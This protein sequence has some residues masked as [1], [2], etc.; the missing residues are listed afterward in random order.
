MKLHIHAGQQVHTVDAWEEN[1][2]PRDPNGKFASGPGAGM[3]GNA[4]FK[5]AAQNLAAAG[6]T[7][8][9]D[10]NP[11]KAVFH[12]G[13]AK[14]TVVTEGEHAGQWMSEYPGKM[15]KYG[16][17]NASLKKI[18][19]GEQIPIAQ[20]PWNHGPP[21]AAF[22]PAVEAEEPSHTGMASTA[23][24]HETLSKLKATAPKATPEQRS[25]IKAYTG[26]HY[27]SINDCL[28]YQDECAD[29]HVPHVEKWL[30]K[31]KTQEEVTVYR[32][33]KGEYAKIVASIAMVGT[34]FVDRGFIST[35]TSHSFAQGWGS[36]LLMRIKVPPGSQAAAVAH[37]SNHPSEDEVLL[38]KGSAL[39][40]VA[41]D[42]KTRTMDVELVQDHLGQHVETQ[43]TGHGQTAVT[44]EEP[45]V[46]ATPTTVAPK[47][48]HEVLAAAQMEPV[49]T[50]QNETTYENANGDT[51]A[52]NPSGSWAA[53][54]DDGNEVNSGHGVQELTSALIS[55]GILEPDA[56]PVQPAAPPVEQPKPK[57][58][59]VKGDDPYAGTHTDH[60]VK[61]AV[62]LGYEEKPAPNAGIRR[63]RV[64][65][66][67]NH[68]AKKQ[69]I[70]P[71]M[72]VEAIKIKQAN[73]TL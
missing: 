69:G 11:S 62:H 18:A 45:A 41:W 70:E 73:G 34:K 8:K 64:I 47:A 32:G 22:S 35:S 12:K 52:V 21:S 65:N 49:K 54:T 3:S 26:S 31:A 46:A 29:K 5:I 59:K 48:M 38:Q 9:G 56:A 43:T 68:H 15:T 66:Y 72:H 42:P 55:F 57:K 20:A 30:Q 40:V 37:L 19:N 27:L 14:I 61:H 7:I 39:K 33:V 44:P 58:L 16:E 10:P 4:G 60:L 13:Q 6:Y 71:K 25:A 1:K 17:G 63:M 50:F 24:S 23:A 53:Y 28:R 67:L 51:I 36:G 2:H